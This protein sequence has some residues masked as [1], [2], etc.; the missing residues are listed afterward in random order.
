MAIQ[1]PTYDS[2]TIEQRPLGVAPI[3]PEYGSAEQS[4]AMAEVMK[5]NRNSLATLSNRAIKPA[6]A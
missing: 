6:S 4:L 1:I 2:P 5:K 3:H